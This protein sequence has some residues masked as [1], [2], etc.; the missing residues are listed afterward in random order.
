[1]RG[2]QHAQRASNRRGQLPH[3]D[4]LEVGE[5]V[6]AHNAGDPVFVRGGAER[7]ASAE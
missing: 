5:D 2:D 1:V 6:V 7:E 3:D 4:G